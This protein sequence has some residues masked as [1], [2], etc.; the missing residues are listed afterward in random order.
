[1]SRTCA[2]SRSATSFAAAA[3]RP[4]PASASTRSSTRS[5][6]RSPTRVCPSRGARGCTPPSR[7]GSS[8]SVR[9]PC[10]PRTPISPGGATRPRPTGCGPEPSP[11]SVVPLPWRSPGTS[12]TMHAASW[13]R[14]SSSSPTTACVQ[15]SGARSEGST[16]WATRV[17]RSGRRWSG[18]SRSAP[19]VRSQP[20]RMRSSPSRRLLVEVCG[21]AGR[22]GSSCRAGSTRRW[23]WRSPR[24]GRGRRRWSRPRCGTGGGASSLPVRRR[25]SRTG[26]ETRSCV[27]PRTWHARSRISRQ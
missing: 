27:H 22:R 5:R 11:G 6:A 1:M 2:C 19:I 7:P 13:G 24:A 23:T 25:S 10:V 26:W 4:W 8:D 21:G 9:T 14:L 20:R 17:R 18:R 12:S 16:L 15:S 3:A